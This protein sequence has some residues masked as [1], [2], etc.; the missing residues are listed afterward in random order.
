MFSENQ[1]S[2][3]FGT[4]EV[5]SGEDTKKTV[6]MGSQKKKTQCVRHRH[7]AQTPTYRLNVNSVIIE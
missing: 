3:L 1:H 4:E 7:E 6:H 5:A 2:N